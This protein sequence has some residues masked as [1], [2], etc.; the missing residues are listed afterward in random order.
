MRRNL[1]YYVHPVQGNGVWQSNVKELLDRIDLFDGVRVCAI[2]VE[3]NL[4]KFMDR[5]PYRVDRPGDVADRLVGHGFDVLEIDN[6]KDW[7]EVAAFR[8]LWNVASCQSG[9]TFYAHAKSVTYSEPDHPSK[10][11]TKLLYEANLDY[12]P[13]VE[14]AFTRGAK[15][16]GSMRQSNPGTAFIYSGSF[17]WFN[18]EAVFGKKWWHRCP[19][20]YG[21]VELWP[22]RVFKKKET[23][24]LFKDYPSGLQAYDKDWMA[25]TVDEFERWK[26]KHAQH[27]TQYE[28][29]V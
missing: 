17:Y 16:V 20:R 23:A 11:W 4:V 28:V 19:K 26:S 2:S 13:L 3:P 5:T 10:A 15:M 25:K 29:P 8:P 27:R 14:R 7:G 21:G 6:N 18:N 12:W 9:V 22:G 1:I 24:C